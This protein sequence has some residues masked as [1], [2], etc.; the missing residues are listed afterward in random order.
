MKQL[1][2]L[3]IGASGHDRVVADIARLNGYTEILFLDDAVGKNACGHYP[4]V[5]GSEARKNY[6]EADV[7]VAIGNATVREKIFRQLEQER[8]NIVSL[9]HPAAAIGEEVTVDYG[10]VVMAGAV[11][12]PGASIGRGCI[13]NT[14]TSV[15]HDC[16]IESFVHI[17]VGS[18]IAG[19]CTVGS[20]TWIGAGAVVSNNINICE[21]CMIGAGA[22]VIK[23]ID[24]GGTYV[25]I[26]ARK[27]H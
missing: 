5:G 4:V 21:N 18:H 10:T 27:V 26:P 12:N 2:L 16:R 20:K 14:G 22:V 19:T 11:I 9:I 3:I 8:R 17:A 25:G 24:L 13:I 6:P 23:S 7:F 1:Q 15:D